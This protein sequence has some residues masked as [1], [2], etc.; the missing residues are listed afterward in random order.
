MS[1]K[2]P[3]IVFI[4]WNSNKVGVLTYQLSYILFLYNMCG[5]VAC[6]YITWRRV[7]SEYPRNINRLVVSACVMYTYKSHDFRDRFCDIF[8]LRSCS[9]FIY[10]PIGFEHH[11]YHQWRITTF[12]VGGGGGVKNVWYV[13]ILILLSHNTS[14]QIS[15][16]YLHT[17]LFSL[18]KLK[19]SFCQF[20]NN[21]LIGEGVRGWTITD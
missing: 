2:I 18:D 4:L 11:H 1:L 6:V 9:N 15:T 20:I 19:F 13:K 3:K 5:R 8:Y 14:Y 7:L 10:N 17:N 12:L 21:C 16:D